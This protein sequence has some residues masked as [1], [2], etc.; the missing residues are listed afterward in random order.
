MAYGIPIAV[1]VSPHGFG[2]AARACAVMLALRELQPDV[3]FEVFTLVPEWFF[4]DSLPFA[5]AYHPLPTDVGLVQ[6]TPLVE[7]PV[8]TLH[9][10]EAFVPFAEERVDG[11]ARTLAALGCR[12]AVCDISPLGIAAAARAGLPSVLIENFT[13]DWI[14]EP[15]VEHLPRF[16]HVIATLAGIFECATVR[17]QTEPVCRPEAR[18]PR[19]RPVSRAP[20]TA[21]RAVREGLGIPDGVPTVLLTVGGIPWRP[22][23]LR[24]LEHESDVV[25][26]VPGAA[27]RRERRGSLVA[28]PHRSGIFHPDLVNAC[29]AVVGKL[30]YST[31]AEVH[32][33]G[34]PFAFVPRPTFRES[35]VLAGFAESLMPSIALTGEEFA[36][37]DWVARVPE[38]LAKPRPLGVRENGATAA[39][40][41]V[42]GPLSRG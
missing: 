6:K 15:Y 13:W 20:R 16:S 23:S 21:A 10:L 17:I 4:A 32:A 27:D 7:D 22:S 5:V 38:L 2:H 30:G 8:E 1:F 12:L 31:V 41:L 35:T 14:Y 19:V 37:G 29:D 40:R 26:V 34:V 28:L 11:L 36:S 39:G 33:A 25:F 24:R 18:S 3:R 9:R 42:L